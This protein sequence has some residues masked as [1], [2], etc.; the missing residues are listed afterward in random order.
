MNPVSIINYLYRKRQKLSKRKVLHAVNWISSKCR[1]NFRDLYI[2]HFNCVESPLL[3]EMNIHWENFSDSSKIHKTAKRFSS[4][5]F[6][7]YG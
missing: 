7:V 2:S 6:V 1:E 4:L 5:T 3:N